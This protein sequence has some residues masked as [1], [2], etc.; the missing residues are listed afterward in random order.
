[1]I[2]YEKLK[3]CYQLVQNLMNE[4]EICVS[5]RI[6]EGNI[7]PGNWI[8][9][10]IQTKDGCIRP[11]NID[12]LITKLQSL[13]QD[14]PKPKYEIGQTL[15][16]RHNQE[17][18]CFDVDD[19]ISDGDFWYIQFTDS[20]SGEFDQYRED[21]VYPTEQ[22]L[23]ESQVEYWHKLW[24][25]IDGTPKWVNVPAS[26]LKGFG[27]MHCSKAMDSNCFDVDDGEILKWKNM[28]PQW[29]SVEPLSS[30]C[31]IHTGTTEE[32]CDHDVNGARR[33]R[34][35]NQGIFARCKKCNEEMWDVSATQRND[36]GGLIYPFPEEHDTQINQDEVDLDG[37]QHESMASTYG[38]NLMRCIKCLDVYTPG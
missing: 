16:T 15:F 30:C 14:K 8:I 3:K 34:K 9:Y 37:C 25:E 13:I 6:S 29:A 21:I 32:C 22:A 33:Y 19:I 17:I 27:A 7:G 18:I 26:Q 1:M 10:E 38:Q 24:N 4:M 35:G 20:V 12:D 28:A 31:S 23:I 11:N 2:D 5:I 36:N